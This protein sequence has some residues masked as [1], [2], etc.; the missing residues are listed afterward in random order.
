MNST[1]LLLISYLLIIPIICGIIAYVISKWILKNNE[2][3]TYINRG[4]IIGIIIDVLF[5]ISLFYALK[6]LT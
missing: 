6:N 5:I 4:I 3:K 2:H 1:Q